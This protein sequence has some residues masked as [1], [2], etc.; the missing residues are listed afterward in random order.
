MQLCWEG[1]KPS[2]CSSS[3]VKADRSSLYDVP[4]DPQRGPG[5]EHGERLESDPDSE[6]KDPRAQVLVQLIEPGADHAIA[7]Q[8]D[9]VVEDVEQI[10]GQVERRPPDGD[11]LRQPKIEVPESG[12]TGGLSALGRPGGR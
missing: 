9:V 8:F 6:T 5:G 1:L 12:L 3:S 4:P 2:H 7:L 11:V 10:R